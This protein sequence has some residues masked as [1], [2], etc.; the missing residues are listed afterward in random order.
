MLN[1]DI[2]NDDDD[3]DDD[4]DDIEGGV[5]VT[6]G[7]DMGPPAWNWDPAESYIQMLTPESYIQLLT[8]ESYIQMLT[9][10]SWSFCWK[11]HSNA[12]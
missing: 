7:R 10:E 8:P 1:N 11:L 4:D 12:D 3:D 6:C 9:P 2:D 5:A